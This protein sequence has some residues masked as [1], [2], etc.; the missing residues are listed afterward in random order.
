VIA[1]AALKSNRPENDVSESVF[2][3]YVDQ[4]VRQCL[5]CDGSS[6]GVEERLSDACT[7]PELHDIAERLRYFFTM[8]SE[9]CRFA[10]DIAE[11]R[12]ES[13]ISRDNTI[14]MPL[15]A[16]QASL[17]H[18]TWQAR[19][20]ADGDLNQ[21][22]S[23]LGDFSDAFNQMTASLREKDSLEQRLL[24]I[25]ET[26]GEGVLLLDARGYAVYMNPEA[27]RLLGYDLAAL[28]AQP[29]HEIIHALQPECSCSDEAASL[30]AAILAGSPYRNDDDTFTCKSGANMPVSVVCRPV[31]SAEGTAGNGTVIAFSD[32]SARKQTE[33]ALRE[34]EENIR[35]ILGAIDN[36]VMSYSLKK[37]QF[38]YV[39][40]ATEKIFGITHNNCSGNEAYRRLVESVHPDDIAVLNDITDQLNTRGFADGEYRVVRPDGSI[41]WVDARIKLVLDDCGCPD[42]IDRVI[43]D[44][45]ERKTMQLRLQ[46][47]LDRLRA[48]YNLPLIGIIT[49]HPEK[50]LLEVN[51]HMCEMLGYS[52][53]E[54]LS[55]K[56]TELT[57]PEDS[58]QLQ[59]I[60][61]G[62]ANATIALPIIYERRIRRKDGSIIN[63]L[64]S[65]NRSAPP[66]K[67]DI[68]YTSFVL[69]VTEQ[70]RSE[71][72]L[73][74]SEMQFR[75]LASNI[76][77]ISYRCLFDSTWT[78][79]YMNDAADYITGYP[80]ADFINNAVRSFAS[81]IYPEDSQHIELKIQEATAAAA[82]WEIE[83]RLIHRDGSIR[84]V[85]EKG[86]TITDDAG[87]IL[88][89]DGFIMDITTRKL[90][91]EILRTS[92]EQFSSILNSI[93]EVVW[94]LSMQQPELLYLSPSVEKLFGRTVDE[95]KNNN[96]LWG[97]CIHPDDLEHICETFG[98]LAETGTTENEYRII[99]PDGSIRWVRARNKII[100]SET[101]TPLRLDGLMIDITERVQNE[102]STKTRLNLIEYAV[103]H[104]TN[105]LLQHALDH[106]GALVDSPIGF[107]H[108]VEADQK[109]L[110]LQQWSTA[111]REQFC[112]ALPNNTHYPI[113]TAGVWA[114][115]VHTRAPVIHNNYAGLP[116]KKGLPEGHAEIVRELVVPVLRD[117]MVV[118]IVGVGNKPADYTETDIAIVAFLADTAWELVLRKRA[119]EHIF[120]TNRQLIDA[121][122]RATEMANR[123]EQA[124]AAK[125]EFL[126]NMSHEIRTPMNGVIGMTGLLL[127]STLNEHQRRYAETVRSSAESLLAIINDILDFSKIEAHKLVLETLDFDLQ[128]LL[129]DFTAGMAVTAHEKGLELFCSIDPDVPG[130]LRGDPGRLRQI[131]TNLVGN[132]IK[133]TDRGEIS[134]QVSRAADDACLDN[135]ALF[136]G[137]SL[138]VMLR[139]SVKDTGIGI[140]EKNID[141]LFEKFTQADASTTRRYGG[142][143]L[144]LAISRQLAGL[145]GGEIGA[146]KRNTTGS[147]FWFT[148][149]MNMQ[150]AQAETA[151]PT[152]AELTGVHIL[153]V[154]DNT[155][156]RSILAAWARSWGMRPVQAASGHEALQALEQ[157]C[158]ADDPVSVAVIDLQ[159]PGMDGETLGRLIQNDP[160]L[161]ATRMIILTSLGSRGD[162]QR[163]AQ[164]G[165]A[166]YLAKP[167]RRH[168]LRG[169]LSLVL[170]RQDT[171]TGPI[172][173]RHAAHEDMPRFESLNARIL[174]AED[175]FTNQQV[176]LGIL[177][178]MGLRADAVANG[179]EVLKALESIPYDL[180]LLDCQMPVMD[181]YETARM[182]R[183]LNSGLSCHDIPIIAMT[184]Y[185]MHGD[186]DKCIA[187]GMNGY[188]S[189]P[190]S[191][192]ELANALEEW[193][194]PG[195]KILDRRKES[196]PKTQS[197]T[198]ARHLPVWDKAG[199]LARLMGD[200][201]LMTKVNAIFLEETPAHVRRISELLETGDLIA[202]EHLAHTIKGACANIGAERMRAVADDIE[203]QTRSGD[204]ARAMARAQDLHREFEQVNK[205]LLTHSS[206]TG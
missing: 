16:L 138:P 17:R 32:I 83:Y 108:F 164:A 187:A 147:E 94:S 34:N 92:E 78:M 38:I 144:G 132:A 62:I 169:V 134:V 71:E 8:F 22:V 182:I 48:Y 91:E 179:Q 29:F 113:D 3:R 145:M 157:A 75:S 20:V 6:C 119:E 112:R 68:C 12:L 84:W 128:N 50:G 205:A 139:F 23:F 166:G 200:Q 51:R 129:D 86:R 93:D 148:V 130:L 107:F 11:G 53:D 63:T 133:F 60:Y 18:L 25:T 98:Q 190:I 116:G 49:T 189:K 42:R 67:S 54:F 72:K 28:S 39:S 96:M 152:P 161:S 13:S 52:E 56:E 172:V 204:V 14:A 149:C 135:K 40:P 155:T 125:S 99:R 202:V 194:P 151:A 121:T 156:G 109:T 5:T 160:R 163:F 43:T 167:V 10:R 31:R 174:V 104:S 159:M 64:V 181:G 74:A 175:N 73:R 154:D 198:H 41:V 111:T 126:A 19:R 203:L 170:S 79:L 201:D 150:P 171:E 33:Q 9:S 90:A 80:A 197:D 103:N 88:Y 146:R 26:I 36:A 206:K 117:T 46:E 173:T 55:K 89:L 57:P 81:I 85:H 180:L 124:S 122:R 87:A 30:Q 106:I 120:A 1:P 4:L 195:K 162:A 141:A 47:S 95:F 100:V 140:P 58:R 69:D 44:I 177:K 102:R 196:I 192:R 61:C 114:E 15:K 131:L 184:A 7:D 143:G 178:N 45:T 137:T 193:L 186:R 70:K 105:D 76:P 2:A 59:E 97:E 115:C 188:V 27:E 21:Q 24:T 127:E 82:P 136:A 110:S 101:G 35:S 123:A 168:E 77:G 199:T 165:F 158:I 191:P 66:G 185:A 142:T 183:D 118:A 37:D 65:T 176:A 153:L